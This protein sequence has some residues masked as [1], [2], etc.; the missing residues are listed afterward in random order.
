MSRMQVNRGPSRRNIQQTR[1]IPAPTG[2]LNGRDAYAAMPATDALVLDNMFPNPSNVALRNGYISWATGLPSAV[3]SLC[4]YSSATGRK[5]F[6]AAGAGIYDV[7]AKGAVGAAVVS[8][9]TSDQWQHVNFGTPGGQ[10]LAMVNGSDSMQLYNGTTWQAVTSSSTPISITGVP[11]ANLIHINMFKGRLFCIEK[12][13]MKAWY[14]P[15]NSIGGAANYLD[16][17]GLVTLGGYLMAMVTWTIDNAGGTDSMAAFITSEGEV[18][19]FRGSDPAYA[20]SWYLQ[21]QFRIGRPVGR[22][23]YV[24]I[25][26][27]VAVIGADGLFPMS[28]ALLTD[29]S[30]R[31]DAVSDKIVN[32][33]N[34]DIQNYSANFGWQA[35]LHPIGN[36]LVVNVPATTGTYQYVMN[37]VNGSWCR[38]TGWAANCWEL[39]GDQLMFGGQTAVYQADTGLSDNGNSIYATAIQA[40]QYFGTAGQKQFTM[41]RPIFYSN[42]SV[43]PA[44]Q[45]NVDFDLTVPALTSASSSTKFTPWGSAWGSPWSSPSLIRKD[46]QNVYGVGFAGAPAMALNVKNAILNW[47]ATDVT[48]INGDPL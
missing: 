6:A 26:S 7:T 37:T 44:F 20:S 16:F 41:A 45:I 31:Q 15:L 28:Q 25:G 4:C 11:T 39:M 9:L 21:G 34:N 27:D 48:F 17:S 38:F 30:Q 43:R 23:C 33:I 14:L 13:S 29:R 24:R 32:L 1:S 46:W 8:G 35:I 18:L 5:L 36:K 2:G 19:L 22:R 3:N 42:A 47:Q 40:P 10:F 12:N